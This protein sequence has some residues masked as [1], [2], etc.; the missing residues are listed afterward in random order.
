[1][2]TRN[3]SN[4]NFSA[5]CFLYLLVHFVPALTVRRYRNL[6]VDVSYTDSCSIPSRG[7]RR[8]CSCRR[9]EL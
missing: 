4:G 3:I 5:Y 7:K 1:L 2:Y 9:G 8:S 6:A